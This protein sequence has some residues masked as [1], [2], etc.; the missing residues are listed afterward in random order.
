MASN[1]P[2]KFGFSLGSPSSKAKLPLQNKKG[3][4]TKFSGRSQS[5][6]FGDDED[7]SDEEEVEL[8]TGFEDN[9]ATEL[10]PKPEPKP[11]SIAPL[12]NIDWR[13][14]TKKKQIYVPAH[15][16]STDG[17]VE[18]NVEVMGQQA[19]AYGLQVQSRK[20]TQETHVAATISESETQQQDQTS[21]PTIPEESKSLD[22]QAM[23]AIMKEATM[24]G[25]EEQKG[26]TLVIA[27]DET[28]AFREDVRNR[29][30][31]ATMEDYEN[32]PVEE[33]GAALL[34]GLGWKEG[35]GI[36]R[37]RK[38]SPAP[39]IAPVKQRD[40]LLGLGAKP[41]DVA[42]DK[43]NKHR[44]AAYEIKET[45]LFKKI[46]KHRVEQQQQQQQK[47]SRDRHGRDRRERDESRERRRRHSRSRSRSPS[48][49]SRHRERSGERSRSYSSSRS[50]RRRSRSR[51]RSPSSRSS[52]KSS[53][54]RRRDRSRDGSRR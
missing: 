2:G 12:P 7:R 47:D 6:G 39:V 9:K 41:E 31:E 22:A 34:R 49:E 24:G 43:K 50:S 51:S 8:L 10:T 25:Q 45:S 29:P 44:R 16:Q 18:S 23:E 19:S 14:Q 40:A 42:K 26:S 13:S 1:G 15:P 37:N 35:E 46:S 21:T 36:G 5:L 54:G 53:S 20:V 28:E 38:N 11:L 52:S 4:Q 17:Q 30:D 32:I 27:A 3:I 33:F 48:R